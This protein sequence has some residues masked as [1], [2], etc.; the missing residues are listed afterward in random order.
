MN[1]EKHQAERLWGDEAIIIPRQWSHLHFTLLQI[2]A[3]PVQSRALSPEDRPAV[4]MVA[5]GGLGTCV[6]IPP[7][8]PI[9]GYWHHIW[10]QLRQRGS[11]EAGRV[12]EGSGCLAARLGGIQN[13]MIAGKEVWGMRCYSNGL[14][15]PWP[16]RLLL[17]PT[18]VIRPGLSDVYQV[19]SLQ[20][21]ICQWP[22]SFQE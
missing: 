11:R 18:L 5:K 21:R 20:K 1:L 4:V 2:P 7:G 14:Q 8:P 10:G 9:R 12:T 22:V 19:G 3:S 17:G 15:Q 6:E 16:P 13:V